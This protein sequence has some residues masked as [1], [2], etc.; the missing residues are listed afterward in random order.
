[1]QF[2]TIVAAI[3]LDD[4]L[5]HGVLETA[6]ALANRDK[7][8]LWVV[9]VWPDLPFALGA[10]IANPLSATAMTPSAANIDADK[11]ARA[12]RVTELETLVFRSAPGAKAVVL[13]GEPAEEIT[14][15]A[16]DKQADLLVVG[17][18]QKGNWSAFFDG[19]PSR[20][21]VRNAPCA[22]FL[23]PKAHRKKTG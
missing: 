19:A 22:I 3:N 5:A 1:M 12:V 16:R 23:V 20:D 11:A 2:H 15:F 4:D 13:G 10:G 9:D 6:A 18:H 21:I 14:N 7:A 17:T 8:N